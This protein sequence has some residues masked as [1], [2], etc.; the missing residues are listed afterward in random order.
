MSSEFQQFVV[1]D[2]D[3]PE[4]R[5]RW[6]ALWQTWPERDVVAHPGYAQL[7]ARPGDRTV[8]AAQIVGDSGVLFP[9]IVRPLRAEAWA[10][11]AETCDLVSPYGYGGPFGWGNTIVEAF[12]SGFDRWVSVVK[13]VSLFARFSLFKERLIPFY[14]DT[15]VKG[16]AVIVPLDRAP[17]AILAS[18]D[19]DARKNVRQAERAG[20]TV[21]PDPDCRRLNEFLDIYYLTMDRLEARSM[22]Y[23][24]REFFES[25]IANTTGQVMLFHALHGGRV[26][27]TEMLLVSADYLYAFLTGTIEEGMTVRANPLLRHAVNV[28]GQ[29]HGKRYLVLGGG[30]ESA[31]DSLYRYKLRYAP[32]SQ[33]LFSVGTRVLDNLTYQGL[34]DQRAAWELA[35]G[36]AWSPAAGFFPAYRG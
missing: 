15:L 2:A 23:F 27:S 29:A 10:D 14:G 36:R 20:V 8:C 9:L 12:W 5:E 17:E 7:F 1:F 3:V 25:L 19:K 26:V 22:Y 33:A 16:P 13:A 31:V 35:Q 34:L 28:W 21:E 4:E 18:Y 11:G 6:L 32:D 24:P 30:Y